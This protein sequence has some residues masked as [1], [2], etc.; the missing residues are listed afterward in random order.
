VIRHIVMWTLR[1]N[2]EGA[3]K[4]VNAAKMKALLESCRGVVSG[5]R[6]FDV[7]VRQAGLEATCDVLL[8]SE[9]E[10]RAALDAYQEHPAHL[11]I[12]PFIGA[13]RLAR[14]CFDYET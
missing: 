10:N 13:V 12:K 8:D 11:A 5:M 3:D 6:R 2:A 4:S 1:D 9:F 7:V 14:Q